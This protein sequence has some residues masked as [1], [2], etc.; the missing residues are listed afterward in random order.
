MHTKIDQGLLSGPLLLLD[1]KQIAHMYG[2]K[3]FFLPTNG[4]SRMLI[5]VHKVEEAGK[6]N[7]QRKTTAPLLTGFKAVR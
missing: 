3:L 5:G 7:S 1:H 6:I 2:C 4:E